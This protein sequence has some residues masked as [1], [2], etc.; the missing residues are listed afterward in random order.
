MTMPTSRHFRRLFALTVVCVVVPL[1]LYFAY[2]S[3]VGWPAT[4]MS[5]S[6]AEQLFSKV[7]KPGSSV[8]EVRNWLA[9]QCIPDIRSVNDRDHKVYYELSQRPEDG[10]LSIDQTG[11]RTA[12]ELA[13]LQNENV[14]SIIR[15]QYPEADRLLLDSWTAISVYIFFDVDGRVSRCWIHE[16]EFGPGGTPK[17]TNVRGRFQS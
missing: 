17:Y 14:H 15:V 7:A 13:G 6:E 11:D 10:K 16:N 9:S 5:V 4:P 8:E 3:F 2:R 12:A 1:G